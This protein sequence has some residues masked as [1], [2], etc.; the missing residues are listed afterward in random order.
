MVEDVHNVLKAYF[1]GNREGLCNAKSKNQVNKF[2]FFKHLSCESQIRRTDE[3]FTGLEKIN[4][5]YQFVVTGV[6]P[7]QLQNRSYWCIKYTIDM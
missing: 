6:G 3:P 4:P 1:G 7:V 2:N 5:C